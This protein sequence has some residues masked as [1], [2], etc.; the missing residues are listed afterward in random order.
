MVL[1]YI[2]T[3]YSLIVGPTCIPNNVWMF[4]FMR[5]RERE[6][7][8]EIQSSQEFQRF[9]LIQNWW[10]HISKSVCLVSD[11]R[12]WG[13]AGQAAG[14]GGEIPGWEQALNGTQSPRY[15]PW[16]ELMPESVVVVST[17]SCAGIL[18][19]RGSP[20]EV[21]N[22]WCRSWIS[23]KGTRGKW[24][25]CLTWRWVDRSAR[26]CESYLMSLPQF[27]PPDLSPILFYNS[28]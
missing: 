17:L 21:T 2:E 9:D 8:S 18:Q 28:P 22:A 16:G 7:V 6:I 5:E 15:S 24:S 3:F 12:V 14:K 19:E 23:R 26:R 20:S 27:H 10:S 4:I 25:C 13:P 11:A 1:I